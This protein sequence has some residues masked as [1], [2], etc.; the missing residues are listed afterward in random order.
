MG[1]DG[2]VDPAQ[3]KSEYP[4]VLLLQIIGRDPWAK[5]LAEKIRAAAMKEFERGN[6][7][8]FI[9]LDLVQAEIALGHRDAALN[10]LEDW[11]R[12]AQRSSRLFNFNQRAIGLYAQLGKVDEEL[13]LLRELTS[14]GYHLGYSLRTDPLLAPIRDDARFQE[15]MKLEEA[16][17]KAQP[18]P[19]DP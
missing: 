12:D 14:N 5:Y 3:N 17:A 10:K 18:D 2:D 13:A 4:N 9:W 7:A 11:R 8:S 6:R 19:V 16:W 15:L 1:D